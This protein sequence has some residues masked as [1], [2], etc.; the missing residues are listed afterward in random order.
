MKDKIQEIIVKYEYRTYGAIKSASEIADMVKAF[1][2]WM[3]FKSKQSN[4]KYCEWINE[5]PKWFT[6]DE[7]FNVE[8]V[9]K[10]MTEELTFFVGF[11]PK[12]KIEENIEEKE[13]NKKIKGKGEGEEINTNQ[14][15]ATTFVSFN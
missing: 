4:D 11:Q 14:Y 1:T 5:R 2:E 6:F 10:I 13:E 7:L 8:A 9:R 12:I 15:D 3:Q